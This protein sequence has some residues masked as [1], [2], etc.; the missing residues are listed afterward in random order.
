MGAFHVVPPHFSCQQIDFQE[1]LGEACV[2]VGMKYG[3][4]QRNF[5]VIPGPKTA[6]GLH[7]LLPS[8]PKFTGLELPFFPMKFRISDID[9]YR[10]I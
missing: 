6:L 10:F 1:N 7:Y 2:F 8:L 3:D 9:L 5:G 4:V